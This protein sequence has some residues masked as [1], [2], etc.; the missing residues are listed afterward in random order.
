MDH[1]HFRCRYVP[2]GIDRTDPPGDDYFSLLGFDTVE[3]GTQAAGDYSVVF[4]M[5]ASMA[6]FNLGIYYLLA[7]LNDLKIFYRWTVPFRM[8][9]FLI[10]STMAIARIAPMAF[11]AVGVW[12]LLGAISTLD[13]LRSERTS[14]AEPNS[15]VAQKK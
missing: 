15:K 14:Q 10:F 9:T 1:V 5:A 7:A 3:H 11:V 8:L 4:T 6:Y 13:S 2:V 12:E